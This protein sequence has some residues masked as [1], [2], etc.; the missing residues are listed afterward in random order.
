[1]IL[2]VSGSRKIVDD[3]IVYDFLDDCVAEWGKPT[4]LLQGGAEGVDKIA[5]RWAKENGIAVETYRPVW[6]SLCRTCDGSGQNIIN[7][8]P[9]TCK[10]CD[11][12][13]EKFQPAAGFMRNDRIVQDCTHFGAVWDGGSGGTKQAITAARRKERPVRVY[14][15]RRRRLFEMEYTLKD[16]KGVLTTWTM[17]LN[18]KTGEREPHKIVHAL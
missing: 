10:E 7:S 11:G 18:P 17:K 13:G 16:P 6:R 3:S 4:L 1:M 2:G 8:K 15:T 14:I 9:T 12:S 5:Q